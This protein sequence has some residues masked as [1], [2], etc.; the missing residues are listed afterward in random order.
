MRVLTSDT[1]ENVFSVVIADEK[2]FKQAHV[3][4]CRKFFGSK[5]CNLHFKFLSSRK[6]KNISYWVAMHFNELFKS[7]DLIEVYVIRGKFKHVRKMI[8]KIFNK[9][10]REFNVDVAIIGSDF[11]KYIKNFAN[12]VTNARID[13]NSIFVQIADLVANTYW[14]YRRKLYSLIRY[15]IIKS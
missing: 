4:I 11:D 13:D 6:R 2:I 10:I 8:I 15:F 1:S 9:R 7:F 14:R 5:Q 3:T 12:K